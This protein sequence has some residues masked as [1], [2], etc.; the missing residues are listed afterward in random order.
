MDEKYRSRK[1]LITVSIGLATVGLAYTGKLTNDVAMIFSSL[2][3]SYN[4]AN[5]WVEKK[6]SV[7]ITENNH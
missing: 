5:A 4:V 1:F 7:S 2:I 3:V 6:T